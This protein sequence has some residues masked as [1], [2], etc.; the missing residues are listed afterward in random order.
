VDVC[1]QAVAGMGVVLGQ[2]SDAAQQQQTGISEV[3]VAV[4]ELD[5]ITQ[6]NAAMVEQLAACAQSLRLQVDSVNDSLR[7]FR[8]IPGESTVAEVDA[9]ALRRRA[10][11]EER[12]SAAAEPSPVAA[13]A[14]RAPARGPRRAATDTESAQSADWASF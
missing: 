6:Q 2:V 5:S 9:V 3:N 10:A 14:A 11:H 7:M 8:L 12:P 13:A 4:T 1:T